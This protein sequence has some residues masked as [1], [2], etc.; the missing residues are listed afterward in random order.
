MSDED[1]EQAKGCTIAA[2]TAAIFAAR[3]GCPQKV[4]GLHPALVQERDK[5]LSYNLYNLKGKNAVAVVGLGHLDGIEQHWG[6][7]SEEEVKELL[8]PPPYFT[9]KTCIL[10]GLAA[11]ASF[12]G[13]VY[14]HRRKILPM[15]VTTGVILGVAAFGS[16]VGSRAV[17]EVRSLVNVVKDTRQRIE[18]S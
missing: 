10:P 6:K 8:K 9:L 13:L 18:G 2:T 12:G 16:F 1:F 3:N 17:T 11:A 5:I 7:V 15:R 4:T 14:L